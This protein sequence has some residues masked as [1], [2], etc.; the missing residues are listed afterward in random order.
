M[1][2]DWILITNSV[3][4]IFRGSNG[5]PASVRVSEGTH[6][7]FQLTTLPP[8]IQQLLSAEQPK[9]DPKFCINPSSPISELETKFAPYFPPLFNHAYFN[10]LVRYTF[11]EFTSPSVYGVAK[12]NL[13]DT[14]IVESLV[15]GVKL[16]QLKSRIGGKLFNLISI[17]PW[18]NSIYDSRRKQSTGGVHHRS[19]KW[20]SYLFN[21]QGWT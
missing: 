16:D 15:N 13:M 14:W 18:I 10:R 7:A 6:Q 17:F 1:K 11:S 21:L 5:R 2:I 4:L 12:T 9:C 8:L 20:R 19:W 3:P